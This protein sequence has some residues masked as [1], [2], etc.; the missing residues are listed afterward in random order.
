MTA[1]LTL[2][3]AWLE[4]SYQPAMLDEAPFEEI[5]CVPAFVDVLHETPRPADP[6][7]GSLHSFAAALLETLALQLKTI[8]GPVHLALSGGYDSRIL[9]ALAE[10]LGLEPLIV[11]DGAEEPRCTLVQDHLGI[12]AARRYNHQAPHRADPYGIDGA[13]LNGFAPL[14][15]AIQFFPADTADATLVAGL[16][17]GEWFQYPATRWL[18]G[19]QRRTEGGDLVAYWIDTWP[20]YWLLPAHWASRYAHAVYPY[21]TPSYAKVAAR[22]RPE[23]LTP[24][25]PD[26]DVVRKAM[27][28][29]LDPELV[30]F[31]WSAHNYPW[32]LTDSQRQRIDDRY[33]D[34][35]IAVF[36]QPEWG[37]PSMMDEAP[38]ACTLAGFATWCQ[39]LIKGGYRLQLPARLN[40]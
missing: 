29:L 16:G 25:T 18:D 2:K 34:S 15:Q 12:P 14:W 4:P 39:Q 7:P 37:Q 31:G 38:H 28:E 19:K 11:S 6:W 30:A 22:A 3:P 27:L 13:T 20:Q 26:L 32:N 33:L 10:N 9:A 17:G 35:S 1:K 40:A 24:A 8:R 21:A 5:H 36:H 23:W